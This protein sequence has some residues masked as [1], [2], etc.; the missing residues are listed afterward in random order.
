MQ[1]YYVKNGQKEGPLSNADIPQ[2]VR[3]GDITDDTLVW[4]ESMSDWKPFGEVDVPEPSAVVSAP[5]SPESESRCS[6][7]GKEFLPDELIEFEGRHVCG[8]CK[9]TFLQQIKENAE[10][11]GA[12]IVRYA[13]FWRRAGAFVIDYI[14]I[15]ISWLPLGLISNGAS[16]GLV[17]NGEFSYASLFVVFAIFVVQM[18]IPLIYVSFMHGK[19]GATLGK[20]ALGIKVVRSDGTPLTF[21]RAI[22]RSFA[23]IVDYMILYIGFIMAGFD[24][25]K[26]ALHD[27]MCDTRVIYK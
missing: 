13:G 22:G 4:N 25:E 1:W 10:I 24:Q 5:E 12:D 8:G 3:R 7:C 26:R 9:P 21:G 17:D 19:F 6:M 11:A 16:A 20:Q 14:L 27:H 23:C 15:Y 2:F 18:M